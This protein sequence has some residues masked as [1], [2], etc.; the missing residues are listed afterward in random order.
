[1]AIEKKTNNTPV[2]SVIVP[3]Y[4]HS[5]YLDERINSILNQTYQNFELILL[6][7][8]STDNSKEIL[9]KY[10]NNPHVSRIEYNDTN[11]GSTFKQWEKGI[12]LSSGD[13][14]WIAESD[15][16]CYPEMLEELVREFENNEKCVLAYCKSNFYHGGKLHETANNTKKPVSMSGKT[17]IKVYLSCGNSVSNASSALFKK[18]VAK[19]IKKDYL[20]YKGAGDR[21]FW[22]YLSEFGDVSIVR[23]RLNIFRLHDNNSTSKYYYYGINQIEDKK[24]LDYLCRKRY[25]GRFILLAS[26]IRYCNSQV[27]GRAFATEEIRENVEKCWGVTKSELIL[28]NIYRLLLNILRKAGLR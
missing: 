26:R 1:M 6:D 22:I 21:L 3:N 18:E 8:N 4:N 9:E 27:V 25:V 11:S 20:D 5:Q 7:D 13:L 17:F 19:Q 12:N 15:D 28:I 24:I 2:V 16:S 10:R 14:I 23:K